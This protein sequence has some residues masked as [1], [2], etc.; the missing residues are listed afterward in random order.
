MTETKPKP[1][2]IFILLILLAFQ[3]LSGL[4]GGAALVL[5]PSGSSI[6]LPLSLLEGSPFGNFLIPGIILFLVLGIFPLIIFSLLRKKDNRAWFGSL[7]V[8][9]ALLIWIG[10]EIAMIGYQSQPPLQL[11]YGLVGF[12]IL[13]FTLLPSVK[14]YLLS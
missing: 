11:I 5:D 1:K 13:I 4:F 8:G 3:A 14:S 6:R 7:V 10:V 12:F 9:L 2:T